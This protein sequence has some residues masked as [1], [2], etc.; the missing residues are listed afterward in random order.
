MPATTQCDNCGALL[1]SRRPDQHFCNLTCQ[2]AWQARQ[3]VTFACK[4]C[5]TVVTRHPDRANVFCS[6]TCRLAWE[7]QAE[8]ARFWVQVDQSGGPDACWPWLGYRSPL[9]Y[10]KFHVKREGKW[11]TRL[12]THVAWELTHGPLP[13]GTPHLHQCDNPPCVNPAHVRPGTQAENVA[14]M[15][16]KGRA[17][18]PNG[19]RASGARLTADQVQ[20]IRVR[21]AAGGV[22]QSA[23]ARAYGVDSKTV[24]AIVRRKAWQHI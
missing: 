8:A 12:A 13:P 21:Y 2:R 24:N 20:D 15:R 11:V 23:L 4:A 5:G 7:G 10:G 3:H 6:R 16:R 17:R 1:H 19:E 22:S 9:G 14:D 18:D